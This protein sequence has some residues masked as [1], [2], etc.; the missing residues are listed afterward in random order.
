MNKGEGKRR[1]R[2]KRR[3]SVGGRSGLGPDVLPAGGREDEVRDG[4]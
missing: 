4:G 1:R 3:R 2:R